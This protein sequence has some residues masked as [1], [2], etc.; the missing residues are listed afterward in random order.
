[1][2]D[3][4]NQDGH[5]PYQTM[6]FIFIGTAHNDPNGYRRLREALDRHRPGRI[7]VEVSPASLV[8]R[9]TIGA[10]CRRLMARRIRRLDLAMNAE[11]RGIMAYFEPAYEYLAVRDYCRAERS[12]FTLIDASLVSLLRF[13]PSIGIISASN[14]ARASMEDG[15]RFRAECLAAQRV[16][17]A[18]DEIMARVC[19]RHFTADR[20]A[21][22]RERM[23]IR[24]AHTAM[25]TRAS[26]PIA[27]VTGWEHCM[28]DARARTL[29]SSLVRDAPDGV[30][31]ERDILPLRPGA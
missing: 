10:L 24:R 7:L 8:L 23:L 12:G 21:S 17:V 1:M 14:L 28:D 29:Y 25:Q 5:Y 3:A 27:C 4:G 13:L 26:D 6:H 19:L 18:G 9:Y 11:L 15:D 2:I 20:I 30:Q 31:F 16:F 22:F